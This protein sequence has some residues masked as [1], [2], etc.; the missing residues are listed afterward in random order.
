M[1]TAKMIRETILLPKM[2][3]TIGAVF[4]ETE[5]SPISKAYEPMRD[6]G[7]KSL[8]RIFAW[9]LIIALGLV[10]AGSSFFFINKSALYQTVLP[11]AAN[12]TA[13]DGPPYIE[14]RVERW[15]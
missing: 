15:A 9:K 1:L 4:G 8:W 3:S 6:D 2:G 13:C 7:D 11:L 5:Q 12:I 10:I 14:A